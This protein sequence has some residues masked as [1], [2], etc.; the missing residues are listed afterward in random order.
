MSSTGL[1]ST[2]LLALHTYI[3]AGR[4]A[5]DS[6]IICVLRSEV[7]TDCGGWGST[8][9][10]LD[11]VAIL[12][13]IMCSVQSTCVYVDVVVMFATIRMSARECWESE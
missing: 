10:K 1:S 12:L 5:F 13:A 11:L 2:H 8:R 9:L 6:S 4:I 3:P 7:R